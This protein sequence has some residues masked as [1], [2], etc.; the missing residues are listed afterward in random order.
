VSDDRSR[1]LASEMSWQSPVKYRGIWPCSV[2]YMNVA[3]LKLT[4]RRTGNQC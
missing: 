3:R 2:L 1:R 4:R